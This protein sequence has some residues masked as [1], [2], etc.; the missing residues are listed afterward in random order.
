MSRNIDRIPT[1]LLTIL[2]NSSIILLAYPAKCLP[3]LVYIRSIAGTCR[4]VY[5]QNVVVAHA[6]H[7]IRKRI[8]INSW[9]CLQQ[10]LETVVLGRQ[11]CPVIVKYY[12]GEPRLIYHY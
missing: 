6:V 7:R 9:E 3:L 12:R 11:E 1:H 4:V 5:E 2:P 8:P 10:L